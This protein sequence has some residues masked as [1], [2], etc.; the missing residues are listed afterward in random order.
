M[1]SY[2]ELPTF[3]TV[4][5]TKWFM[6]SFSV[7]RRL[8]KKEL[9]DIIRLGAVQEVPG[10]VLKQL[11]VE[12]AETD[13]WMQ[14]E[15]TKASMESTGK[16]RPSSEDSSERPD[17]DGGVDTSSKPSH[18]SKRKRGHLRNKRWH[19]DSLDL[20]VPLTIVGCEF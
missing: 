4:G 19:E 13:V 3:R 8:S 11:E 6:E 18:R 15:R 1:I 7:Y 14:V 12:E 10:E 20:E 9:D 17:F 2:P 16:S 5:F